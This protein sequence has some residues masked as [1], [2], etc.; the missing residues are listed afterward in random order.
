[1]PTLLF[2][3]A[4]FALYGVIKY[5]LMVSNRRHNQVD[6]IAFF[7]G[8]EPHFLTNADAARLRYG[9][10]HMDWNGCEVIAVYNAR[11]LMG[12][13]ASMSRLATQFQ[14]VG[15]MWG[16]GY[17]GSD[18]RRIGRIL[19]KNG[20][21]YTAFHTPDAISQP[22]IYILSY[23]TGHPWLSHLHTVTMV[24]TENGFTTYN[25]GSTLSHRPPRDY[26]KNGFIQGYY[27]KS[28]PPM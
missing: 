5:L 24:L 11:V 19:E 23:W 8:D 20:M 9:R 1:M 7:P 14:N 27:L 22:G 18:P 4:V 21:E 16:W 6:D 2:L 13:K 17:F 26:L 25:Q 15:A 28:L 3:L 10:K 12:Q